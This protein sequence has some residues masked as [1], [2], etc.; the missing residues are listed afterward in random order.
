MNPAGNQLVSHVLAS[1]AD[2]I[3]PFPGLLHSMSSFVY[4]QNA[5]QPVGV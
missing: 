1:V 2:R 3:D 4:G 5:N